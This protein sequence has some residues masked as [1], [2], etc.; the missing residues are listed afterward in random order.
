MRVPVIAGN[1]KMYKTSGEAAA[2][3]RAFLPLVAGV[4]EV[5][6]VLAPPFT[7]I[8]AVAEL[9]RGSG[10]KVSSQNVH[11]ADEGAYTGEVSPRMLVDAGATHC[12]IG[13]SERRQYYA[14]TDDAVNRKIKAA[15]A[16]GLTPIF[17]LGE[18]LSQREAGNTFDVVETQLLGGLKEIPAKEAPKVIVAYEPVWAIGTGRTATPEQAQDVHAF[19]RGRLKGMWD[20]AAESVRILY[21]GS[22][23]PDNIATLMAKPDI[24][25]ALVGGASLAA[26]S[27]AKIVKFK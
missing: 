15:L 22:V 19:L 9:V 20:D 12:I 25:G 17:C 18:T 16:A 21:G 5:E 3:V 27:F 4:R 26:D 2:F 13:H 24:D 11:F 6:I 8:A 23:K 7:S 14:E 10:V 1:W